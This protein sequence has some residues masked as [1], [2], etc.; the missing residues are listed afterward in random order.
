MG[1]GTTVLILSCSKEKGRLDGGAWLFGS[2]MFL[3]PWKLSNLQNGSWLL[4]LDGSATRLSTG[5]SIWQGRIT[6]GSTH[7]LDASPL[8]QRL[9]PMARWACA[10]IRIRLEAPYKVT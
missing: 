10:I 5:I 6:K 1:V 2:Q 4:P 7:S 3:P 8:G 9:A